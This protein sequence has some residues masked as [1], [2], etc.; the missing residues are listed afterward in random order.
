[1][2]KAMIPS[3]LP[4]WP[5]NFV[6]LTRMYRYCMIITHCD[7]VMDPER[8][9]MIIVSETHVIAPQPQQA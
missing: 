7:W 6:E 8:S 1:V 9:R 2:E 3:R 5:L 4:D